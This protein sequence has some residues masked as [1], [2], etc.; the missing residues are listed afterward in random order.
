VKTTWTKGVT[1]TQLCEDIKNAFQSSIVLRK[2]LAAILDDKTAEKE[3]SDMNGEG[4]ECP[5]WAYRMADSQG[6]KRALS[7]IISLITEK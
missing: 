4:Y 6:Y 7:E 1:D 2:R 5:N 3:R